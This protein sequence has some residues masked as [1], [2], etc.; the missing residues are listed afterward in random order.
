MERKRF[1]LQRDTY[2]SPTANS[3]STVLYGAFDVET[4]LHEGRVRAEDEIT[5][6]TLLPTRRLRVLD[7]TDVPYDESGDIFYL[8]NS[9]LVFGSRSHEEQELGAQM[10]K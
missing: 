10:N 9:H 7:L 4:C 8:A 2:T 5:V 6:A 3:A 1:F